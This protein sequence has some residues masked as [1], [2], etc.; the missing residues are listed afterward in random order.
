MVCQI[1]TNVSFDIPASLCCHMFLMLLFQPR[2][3][4]DVVLAL[5][6]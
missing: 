1:T 6:C 2:V 5:C 4:V 3:V